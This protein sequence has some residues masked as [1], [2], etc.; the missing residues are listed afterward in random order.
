MAKKK[1]KKK[2]DDADALP[3]TYDQCKAA[4]VKM[5]SSVCDCGKR[6][7]D[8]AFLDWLTCVAISFQNACELNEER[9]AVREARYESIRKR[10]S[11]ELFEQFP[12]M[13]A[14]MAQAF[15]RRYGDFLGE[16]YETIGASNSSTGQ[17]F[18]PY[19]VCKCMA[20]MTC[21]KDFIQQ[22]IAEKG[23]ITMNE[24]SC[25]GGANIFAVLEEMQAQG[26]NYQTQCLV[27]AQ[28]IDRRCA[29]MTYVTLCLLHVPAVVIIGNTLTL[30]FTEALE[31]P[32]L[33]MQ[34]LK[35]RGFFMGKWQK[36]YKADGVPHGVAPEPPPPP[37]PTVIEADITLPTKEDAQKFV[38]MELF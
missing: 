25:G 35:F 27:Q 32:S 14:L 23:Y 7:A 6:R 16:V 18:T 29:Y 11:A 3:C 36:Q 2:A 37:T 15:E 30:E 19:D 13:L 22:Q 8:E 38:Q 21:T 26:F 31:T 12:K 4:F 20:K 10:Y 5:L 17:F 28:D 34:W 1:A 33:R 24:P 9:H